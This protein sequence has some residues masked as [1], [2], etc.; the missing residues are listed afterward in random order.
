MSTRDV[1]E[2]VLSAHMQARQA[3]SFD[4]SEP[5]AIQALND[6]ELDKR[7]DFFEI[8]KCFI[9]SRPP[10]EHEKQAQ[11]GCIFA[12]IMTVVLA[13]HG[14]NGVADYLALVDI[15]KALHNANALTRETF[16]RV[17]QSPCRKPKELLLAFNEFLKFE[18][19]QRDAGY[20]AD[21]LLIL[22]PHM[23]NI[24][25]NQEYPF[26]VVLV[27][28]QLRGL[29]PTKPENIEVISSLE[30]QS[31]V[32]KE[33]WLQSIWIPAMQSGRFSQEFFDRQMQ[34]AKTTNLRERGELIKTFLE[35][36]VSQPQ[37]SAPG[38]RK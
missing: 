35:E 29:G 20:E 8:M 21:S 22:T 13:S 14:Y 6:L 15:W 12:A 10:E 11:V 17:L 1:V 3:A 19:T 2:R 38:C 18:T 16:S 23:I 25:T 24:I 37:S 27:L 7:D 34:I 26:S 4:G 36:F 9:T 5:L 28:L 32:F 31:Y 30:P 33:R